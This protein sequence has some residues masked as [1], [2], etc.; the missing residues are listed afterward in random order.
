M[1]TPLSPE[2][3]RQIEDLF[4]AA[5][6]LAPQ[7]R[8]DFLERHCDG[9]LR[10]YVERLL[11]AD[12]H[13]AD[14]LERP[15]ALPGIRGDSD[16][17]MPLRV[18]QRV[19]VYEIVRALG[20]GGMGAVYLAR[21]AD[22]AYEQ[23]VA[24]KTVKLHFGSR[25]ALIERFRQERQILAT[26]EHPNICK[27]L[28]GGTTDDGRPYLV[29]EYVEGTTLTAYAATLPLDQRLGLFAS[30]CAAV[31]C[32]HQHLIVHRDIKPSNILVT[33]DGVP[34]LLD[35]GIA[36]LLADGPAAR[37]GETVVT[38]LGAMTPSY[39]S[40]DRSAVSRSPRPAMCIPSAS[41][42][43]S[44]LADAARIRW[45]VFRRSKR[46]GSFRNA[47]RN[48][49]LPSPQA[50]HGTHCAV[51]WT[52]SSAWRCAKIR[53]AGTRRSNNSPMTFGGIS[54]DVQLRR[55]R[56]RQRTA[57]RNSSADTRLRP[58]PRYCWP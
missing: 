39:A 49:H 17:D 2:R 42:C 25:R 41:C 37:G 33:A 21:R 35:F 29:M 43:T 1:N 46:R 4:D 50:R 22:G 27:L 45:T 24:I 26:L 36:K 31:H 53:N 58:P 23:R 3:W 52:T 15:V 16:D 54:R 20:H 13:A 55:D 10:P 32:G 5:A 12:D 47:I 30:V 51:I 7:E 57:R 8:S 40:P 38:L 6:D 28:D 9:S 18:G 11:T 14:F 56:I 34:K 48:Y 19:G 44:C